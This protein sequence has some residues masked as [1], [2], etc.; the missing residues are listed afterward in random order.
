MDLVMSDEPID[1]DAHRNPVTF[2]TKEKFLVDAKDFGERTDVYFS[3]LEGAGWSLIGN[4]QDISGG[5]I[6]LVCIKEV[7]P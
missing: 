7:T 2:Y 3:A 4:Y 6:E 5:H 1:L